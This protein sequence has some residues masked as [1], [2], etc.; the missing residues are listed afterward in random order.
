MKLKGKLSLKKLTK[1]VK[2]ETI[3]TIIVAFTDHYGRMVGKRFDAE[4]FSRIS[5]TRWDT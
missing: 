5:S 2:K 3:E 1:M 4:F